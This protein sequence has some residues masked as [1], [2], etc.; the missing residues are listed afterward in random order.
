MTTETEVLGVRLRPRSRAEALE[1]LRGLLAGQE[2]H[3]V[4][5]VHAAT[6]NL[7]FEDADFR[8]ALNRGSLVLNDGVGV[9]LAARARGVELSDN[10]VGTD[11]IPGLLAGPFERPLR[12]FL[13]GGRPGVAERAG[14]YLGRHFP[15]VRVAGWRGGYFTAEQE[16]EVVAQVRGAA[17]DLVLVG[18]GN[19]RQELFLDRHLPGLGCRLAMG[20]G[21][22][23]DH[24]AGELRRASPGLRRWGLEW[25]QLL[26]QQ[27]HKWRRYL[28]GGPKFVWRAAQ[29]AL[30]RWLVG[31]AVVAVSV[32]A[33]LA[34]SEGAARRFQP[35]ILERYPEGLYVASATRQYRLRPGFRGV[36]RYPEFRTEVRISGQGLR[37][38]REYG[39]KP[40]GVRRILAVG[41][42]FTMGY[43]VASE[44]TWV[45]RLASLLGPGY[46]VVNA[47]VPG[48]ST[49]QELSYLGE[50]GLALQ[51]DVVLLAFFL[52]ND[53]ADNA[54][55]RLPVE[56]RD[57]KL[58][59]S[60]VPRGVL[61]VGARMWLA[62]HSHLY[63]LLWPVQRA[64]RGVASP[65]PEP[66]PE[67]GWAATAGLLHR[68][69]RLCAAHGARLVVVVI[70]DRAP[71]E[72]SHHRMRELCRG[73]GVEWLD[74]LESLGGPGLY[75]PQDGHWTE[76]GNAA[77]ARAIEEYLAGRRS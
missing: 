24:W 75:Y 35:Q 3:S 43:S 65:S 18:M 33:G 68:A 53:V 47:G 17:P 26:F 23:L 40:E 12:V 48:Y 74:L 8:A 71:V 56:L 64:L 29:P 16:S 19:P 57:G 37:E 41:D 46:E 9:R 28:L 51:P 25:A 10:L 58:L 69:E 62:Q 6:A 31:S 2:P 39:L 13:L 22:L 7:A 54:R 52:G 36:F 38:D 50:E 4:Y 70:P 67:A 1:A 42:S 59:A 61:P 34:V 44:Q 77:A 11:L 5:F 45:R 55:A 21:G 66:Y 15:E 14:R 49:W 32:A 60:P 30:R 63:H 20:V 76:R 72:A 27:P 73:T